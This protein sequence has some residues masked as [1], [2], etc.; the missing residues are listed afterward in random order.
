[1]FSCAPSWPHAEVQETISPILFHLLLEVSF[2]CFDSFGL[3][4]PLHRLNSIL[5]SLSI[6]PLPLSFHLSVP[7][8]TPRLIYI[9]VS[10]TY[11]VCVLNH[12]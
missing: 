11:C 7:S 6:L 12:P 10:K 8:L 3:R 1:V 4:A 2:D 9:E 5:R